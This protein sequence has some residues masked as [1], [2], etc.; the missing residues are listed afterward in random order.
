MTTQERLIQSVEERSLILRAL[1]FSRKCHGRA[2]AHDLPSLQL[3]KGDRLEPSHVMPDTHRFHCMKLPIVAKFWRMSKTD[4]VLHDSPLLKV[5]G[6]SVRMYGVDL[7]HGLHLGPEADYIGESLWFGVL[8]SPYG[9]KIHTLSC[10]DNHRI[11]LLQ[12]KADLMAF[13]QVKRASD[14]EWEKRAS[15]VISFFIIYIF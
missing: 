1:K 12:I 2:L 9:T 13:F 7:L 8:Q 11:T 5:T 3:L 10:D 4:R 6:S 14:P 15:M